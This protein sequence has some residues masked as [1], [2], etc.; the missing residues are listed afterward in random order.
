MKIKLSK[1]QWETMGKTAGWLKQQAQQQA[2]PPAQQQAQQQAQTPTLDW[3]N[4]SMDKVL[5]S[6][7]IQKEFSSL[8]SSGGS[9]QTMSNAL[10]GQLK[11][12]IDQ[13]QKASSY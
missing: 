4:S 13:I 7:A 2:Q 8:V 12:L 6:G 9:A 5:N 3:I 10:I 11:M 1:S